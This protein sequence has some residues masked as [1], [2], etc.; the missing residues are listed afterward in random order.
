MSKERRLMRDEKRLYLLTNKN[1]GR[2]SKIIAKL[3]RRIA[4]LKKELNWFF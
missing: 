2:S 1:D 4:N 3:K